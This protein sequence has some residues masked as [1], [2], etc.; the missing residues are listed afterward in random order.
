MNFLAFFITD[1]KT[2]FFLDLNADSA[3]EAMQIAQAWLSNST[4]QDTVHHIRIFLSVLS[5]DITDVRS[6]A[7]IN[8]SMAAINNTWLI[9]P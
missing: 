5:T 1:N 9:V 2:N 3:K 6:G 7:A 4:R 8:V